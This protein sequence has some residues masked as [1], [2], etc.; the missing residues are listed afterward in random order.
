MVLLGECCLS[1]I[2][3]RFLRPNSES[4]SLS[5]CVVEINGHRRRKRV[6][7]L[8]SCE[9]LDF[10]KEIIP[11]EKAWCLQKDIVRE[12]KSEIEKEGDCNDTLI[13]LQHPSVYTLGTASSINNL[14]FDI[15]NPPFHIHRTER[16]GEVTYHGPGQVLLHT[17]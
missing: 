9:L 16:G 13:V 5:D 4:N 12:K 14:N 15:N 2:T 17:S 7:C 6:H 3:P 10:H 11:Y 1:F 8:R